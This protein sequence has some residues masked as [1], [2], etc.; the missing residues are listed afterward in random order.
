V[1]GGG[2]SIPVILKPKRRGRGAARAPLD[3]GNEGGT[4]GA[5]FPLP[6]STGGHPM[7]A[8]VPG[9]VLMTPGG[10]VWAEAAERSGLVVRISMEMT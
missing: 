4:C 7:A 3:E 1:V 6:P 2:F 9:V 10:P 8:H 5:S